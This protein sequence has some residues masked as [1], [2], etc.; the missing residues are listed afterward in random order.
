MRSNPT[1]I[2][3]HIFN[4]LVPV[5]VIRNPVFSVPSLHQGYHHG[6]GFST[7]FGGEIWNMG[8]GT[9][10]QRRLFDYFVD[11]DG[12]P[13][14]VVD[15][16]DTVW[17]TAELQ[18]K[19]PEALNIEPG[20]LSDQWEAVPLEKRHGL[21]VVRRFLQ[22]IDESTGIEHP[23]KNPP[24][25]N[26]DKAYMKW[27]DQCGEDHA[28]ELKSAVELNMPHYEYMAQFKI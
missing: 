8:S 26:L 17:R 1:V 12:K 23:S 15:G 13:P 25:P 3:D 27:V 11:R 19:L 18:Y 21:E 4:K 24:D 7:R 6:P 9:A 16:D 10:L 14:L 5:F 22:T 28:K 2:P 20:G